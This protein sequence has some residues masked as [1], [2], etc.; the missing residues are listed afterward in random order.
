MADVFDALTSTRVYRRDF[1]L[2]ETLRLMRE[3]R[4]SHFDPVV[5]NAFLELLP[6]LLAIGD[7]DASARDLA[8]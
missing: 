4:G 7:E 3:G 2:E 5:L 8:A 1:R 6:G